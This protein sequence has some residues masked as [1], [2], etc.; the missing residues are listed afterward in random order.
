M[1]SFDQP[2]VVRHGLRCNIYYF[3]DFV[4]RASATGKVCEGQ[5]TDRWPAPACCGVCT[6]TRQPLLVRNECLR[7]WGPR[8]RTSLAS[9][10]HSETLQP[11]R[12]VYNVLFGYFCVGEERVRFYSVDRLEIIS[13]TDIAACRV[14]DAMDL[15]STTHVHHIMTAQPPQPRHTKIIRKELDFGE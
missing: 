10:S 11:I 15:F 12:S 7:C 14:S 1:L 6:H 9:V 13:C 5:G 3:T 4:A 2:S 8:Y